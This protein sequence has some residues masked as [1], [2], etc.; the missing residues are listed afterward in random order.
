M[1]KLNRNMLL[2]RKEV[3]ETFGIPKRFLERIGEL[4]PPVV[5]FGGY[6]RYRESDIEGWIQ[7]NT[8]DPTSN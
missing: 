1:S 5:R 2:T 3:E 8:R 7:A 4:G 6:V